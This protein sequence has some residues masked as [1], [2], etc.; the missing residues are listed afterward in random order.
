[1]RSNFAFRLA[2]SLMLVAI[3]TVTASLWA[4]SAA[5]AAD[6]PSRP[7]RLL[8]PFPPGGGVDLLAR[9]LG[10]RLG[11]ALRQQVVVD[12]RAGGGGVI[13]T[14]TAAKAPADGYTMLLGF[15][16]PLAI[17]PTISKLPYDPVKDFAALDPL[18]SSYHIVVINPSLPARSVKEFIAL[19]K[20]QPGK[21]NYASSGSG[22][23]LHLAAEL[24]KMVAG[25]NL[26][27][28]P[29]KGAGPAASAVLAGESHLFF[30]SI[31]SSMPFV[32]ANRLV[33]LAVTSPQRSPLAPEI[34]TLI[35]S[36]VNGVNVPSWYVLVVPA[37]TPRDVAD[38]L[39]SELR[40]IAA[41]AE[42]REQLARQAFETRNLAPNEF[43]GFLKA[44]LDKW[45]KVVRAVGI[46]PD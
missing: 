7:L 20:R 35:E 21:L 27:H 38:R 14:D 25:V 36:G 15:I 9:M 16:G 10:S 40:K 24:F 37:R 33:A 29:Y 6:Y 31:T 4:A 43:S 5:V 28:V 22:T 44:E 13:A 2:A 30:G 3:P 42:F 11:E 17:S 45:G 26:V 18:A 8:V 12:N 23:N 46:K 19:A 41:N 39:R 34:P 32:R 1:M